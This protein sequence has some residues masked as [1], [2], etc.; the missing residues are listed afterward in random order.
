MSDGILHLREAEM[1]EIIN[2]L[3]VVFEG[4]SEV[5]G[6]AYVTQDVFPES[7]ASSA[8]IT[9]SMLPALAH[10]A[11]QLGEVIKNMALFLQS[12]IAE[13]SQADYQLAVQALS[14]FNAPK[15]DANQ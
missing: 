10:C 1:T 12:V 6:T 9:N 8:D 15:L 2:E 7:S 5:S 13:F 14:Q 3:A 4:L 11:T